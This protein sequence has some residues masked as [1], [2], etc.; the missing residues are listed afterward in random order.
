MKTYTKCMMVQ[1]FQNNL[2]F[3][4]YTILSVCHR[5]ITSKIEQSLN[6]MNSD[7][8]MSLKNIGDIRIKDGKLVSF[9]F[10]YLI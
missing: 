8:G 5:V 6:R 3:S 1:T 2:D 9:H 4:L 7:S 10:I